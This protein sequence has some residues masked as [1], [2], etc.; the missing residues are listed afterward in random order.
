[1]PP[2]NVYKQHLAQFGVLE[3]GTCF[4][5]SEFAQ[6]LQLN[7]I[8]HIECAPYHRATNGLTER[9]VQIFKTGMRKMREGGI[10]EK[11]AQMLFQHKI[12]IYI[13]KK[14]T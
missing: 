11:L 1:M 3:N 14:N 2:F 8:R 13:D 6:F 9:V 7:G 10:P 5:N 12:L 4:T